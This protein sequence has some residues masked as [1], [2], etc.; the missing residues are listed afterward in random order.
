MTLEIR[1]ILVFSRLAKPL[2]ELSRIF[3]DPKSPS[4]LSRITL[5]TTSTHPEAAKEAAKT[6]LQEEDYDITFFTV[7][8]IKLTTVIYLSPVK[9]S[10]QIL[11]KDRPDL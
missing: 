9:N 5:P 3:T 11:L 10:F 2:E 7:Y 4:E 1:K 6:L 8:E